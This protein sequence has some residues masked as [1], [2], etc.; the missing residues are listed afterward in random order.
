ML[1]MLSILLQNFLNKMAVSE[2][3]LQFAAKI[4]SCNMAFK[5][6]SIN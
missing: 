5:T 3:A 6:L 2:M 1:T 4:P